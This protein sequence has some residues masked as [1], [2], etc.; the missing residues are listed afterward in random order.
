MEVIEKKNKKHDKII[1]LNMNCG[2]CL[3]LFKCT[4]YKLLNTSNYIEYNF[5]FI[6]KKKSEMRR[7]KKKIIK[8]H[9]IHMFY[10]LYNK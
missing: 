1:T 3:V 4:Q 9:I 2:G 8:V 6:L 5:Y 10:K 7:S